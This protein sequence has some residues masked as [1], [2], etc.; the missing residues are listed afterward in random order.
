MQW[1]ILIVF[2][3]AMGEKK[4]SDIVALA[5]EKQMWTR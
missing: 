1:A 2:V 5:L 4:K 3:I